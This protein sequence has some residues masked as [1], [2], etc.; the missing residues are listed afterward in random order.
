MPGSFVE[1]I[2]L[3]NNSKELLGS[4]PAFTLFPGCPNVC[5][6]FDSSVKPF[7]ATAG[8]GFS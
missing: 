1:E 2:D 3:L 6:V 7:S 8:F 5:F 4:M